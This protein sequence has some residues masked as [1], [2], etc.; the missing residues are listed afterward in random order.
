MLNKIRSIILFSKKSIV[1]KINNQPPNQYL[2]NKSMMQVKL[3]LKFRMH[4]KLKRKK[5]KH[6]LK[7]ISLKWKINLLLTQI[8]TLQIS[9][10]K[11]MNRRNMTFF[12]RRNMTFFKLIK[13]HNFQNQLFL[14]KVMKHH[15][16][17]NR[18][19]EQGQHK[20]KGLKIILINNKF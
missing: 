1:C 16:H 2:K 10:R 18:I 6:N 17:I 4:Q 3:K 5:L 11:K 8:K 15:N 12:N 14:L 20:T 19:V 7:K 9:V 13:R